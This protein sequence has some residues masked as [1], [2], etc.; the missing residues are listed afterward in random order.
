MKL[1]QH[2]SLW[3]AERSY[4]ANKFNIDN[5]CPDHYYAN[6]KAVAENILEPI[7][8]KFKVPFTPNSWYRSE[9]LNKRIGG[10][11]YSQH[12]K[13]QA[14]DIEV[15]GVNNYDLFQWI[16]NELEFDQLILEFYNPEV[17][18]SGW[19]HVSYSLEKNRKQ[20]LRAYKEGR[21]TKYKLVTV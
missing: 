10:S 5:T 15:P 11:K 8:S 19:V 20:V 12:L 18:G 4:F 6:L 2:F 16:G 7:R 21:R 1:S 9:A 13:G 14:V 3:E 17:K